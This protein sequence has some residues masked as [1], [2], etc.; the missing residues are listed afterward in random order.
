[1]AN[2]GT[3]ILLTVFVVCS[4]AAAAS[5]AGARRRSWRL[6]ESGIGAFHLVTAMMTVAS[7]IIVH[8]FAT[9]DYSI[10]YVQRYSDASQPLF[11][12]LTSYWGGLDGSIM[13]W[14][15][16]L[17]AFGSIAVHVNRDRHRELIPYVVAT[18]AVVQM[19]FVFLM[20][21]HNNPFE[22]FLTQAPA[23]GRGLNPL[24]Q[25]FYMAIHPPS[26]YIGFVGMT[27]PFAFGLAALATGH[28]DDSWL[29]AVRRWTMLSWLFLSFGLTL[30]MLWAYEELGW[31][32][33]WMWDPVEN[34]GLLPWFTA[35]A[36]LHSV[37]VQER[38]GML[39]IWNVALVIV[40]FFL[41]I[42]GTFMTRSGIVQSVHAFGEDRELAWMFT[43]FMILT[44][45]VSFGLLIYRLP[46]LRSR[47]QLDAWVSRE[48]A[49]LVNNWILLF[50]AF[51]VL[52]ATMFPTLSEATTGERLTVGPPF[53]NKWMAPIG[54]I[55][56]FLTGVGPL[57][58][59]RRSTLSNLRD[60]FLFPLGMGI[61]VGATVVALG[62]RVWSSGLCFALS[63]FVFGTILQEFWRGARVR[64]GATGTDIA[65]ALIGLVARS[66]RRYGGYIV[67][68]GIVLIFLGF[69][70]EGFKQQEQAI[71]KPGQQVQVGRFLVRHD[72]IRVSDDGQKQ[73]VTGNVTV[74]SDG[75]VVGQ[76]RPARWF[77][78]KFEQEPTTEVAIRRGFAED[79]YVTLAGYDMQTQSG[80]YEVTV[81]PL[82]NWIWAGFGIMALGTLIALL[83]ESAYA[84]ASARMPAGAAG[85]TASATLLIFAAALLA[86]ASVHAQ[87]VEG[88][89]V[90]VVPRTPLEKQMQRDLVCICGDCGHKNL[91]ECTCSIAARMRSELAQQVSLGK[92]RDEIN[93]WFVERYGSQEPLGAPIDRGFNR[94]AWFVPYLVGGAGLL[95]VAIVVGRW[96]REGAVPSSA[97]T[98]S[99]EKGTVPDS[100]L[101]AR[102][103]DE[104]RDLD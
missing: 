42:F 77:F 19:F 103:D 24:L 71:L 59:W 21:I 50:S 79:L 38:R 75:K 3:F 40:T 74:L 28:L 81:N 45:T 35:T 88:S 76:L 14:V 87:H 6:V 25:N 51:F 13:F 62:V 56:L 86:P 31:G 48:A 30:G 93:A 55:L 57:L 96:R 98:S 89:T 37:M 20:V 73:M 33:Y 27:I 46:L 61:A 16:L 18:V 70:G 10:K 95:G 100:A 52:F 78:R 23:D 90:T 92:G 58:A 102:L 12:K 94:L 99:A 83:P 47:N 17:A 1:M 60:Q 104:L 66:R 84:Y 7:A 29:R 67:H 11:Y 26:L 41:T 8:A 4:Y 63:G 34:A 97:D 91:A 32:G 69:A 43:G 49:F 80:T 39:R 54:L 2:L 9:N 65:T 36:F 64:Q 44:L 82:V 15:F 101:N 68:V 5:V 85:A 22:T 53:F 72:A